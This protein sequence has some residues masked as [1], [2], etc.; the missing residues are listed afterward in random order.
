MENAQESDR[1]G[2]DVKEKL[3]F[4][5]S[6]H[7]GL[8]WIVRCVGYCVCGKITSQNLS[9]GVTYSCSSRIKS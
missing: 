4:H 9:T 2:Y 6:V 8:S 1:T 3:G 5:G 7:F